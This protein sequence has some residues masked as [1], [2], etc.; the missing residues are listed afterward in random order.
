MGFNLKVLKK[1]RYRQ[2][3]DLL[4]APFCHLHLDLLVC[5]CLSELVIFQGSSLEY[6]M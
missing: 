2:N 3:V 6:S 1:V 4:V 5:L